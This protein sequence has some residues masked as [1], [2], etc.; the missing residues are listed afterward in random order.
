MYT[1]TKKIKK[2]LSSWKIINYVFC[3]CLHYFD[4]NEK[5]ETHV[6]VCGQMNDC[7]MRLPSEDDK[8]LSF[9]N[10]CK[11]KRIPFNVYADFEYILEKADLSSHMYHRVF[12]IRYYVHCSYDD[13]LSMYRFCRGKDCIAWFAEQLRNL[14]QSIKPILSA[15]VAM[16]DF[17]YEKF[18]STT[19][20]HVCEKPLPD[21]TWVRDHC[22]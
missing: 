18:N 8:W 20:C 2:I 7:A 3:R 4:L 12:S 9:N 17:D 1:F 15:N 13:S 5:L 14:A 11:K 16:V 21:D 22:H 19:H 10:Y 6:V